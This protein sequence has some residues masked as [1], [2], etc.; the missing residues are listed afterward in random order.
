MIILYT[1]TLLILYSL[2]SGKKYKL[3]IGF[4]FVFVIMAFQSNV[5][6]DY[7][8][9]MEYFNNS[10]ISSTAK[11]E[12]LWDLLSGLFRPLGWYVYVFFLTFFQC[13][14]LTKLTKQYVDN[15]YKW[16]SAVIFFFTFGLMLIQMKALRQ[17]LA[18]GLCMLPYIIDLA[19]KKRKWIYCFV[20]LILAYLTHN[21]AIIT[22]PVVIL[23]YLQIT[24]GIFDSK[25]HNSLEFFY[26][27]ILTVAFLVI[28]QLKTTILLDNL[29][30]LSTYFTD[31]RL[32]SY[33][34]LRETKGEI[35]N[36]SW[37]IVAGDAFFIFFMTWYYRFA[38]GVFRPLVIM[39]IASLFFD[40]MFFGMGT[41][42]RMGYYY[43]I[44]II[45]VYPN[46]AGLIHKRYGKMAALAFIALSIVYAVKTSLPWLFG[47]EFDQFGH[48]KFFFMQ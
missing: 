24:R 16:Q 35:F 11:D 19:D 32:S 17:A 1:G 47:T 15:K 36:V 34:E 9:Y 2:V 18:I 38:N 26:P 13:F 43:L 29:I 40:C 25:H 23:Y 14:V 6:G 3:L 28:Y 48:Y 21:S 20:P 12:P 4:A 39:A 37:L 27:S 30:G 46:V 5:G 10:I 8:S 45:V 22:L 41:L 42:P 7:M 33:M 31:F 44:A